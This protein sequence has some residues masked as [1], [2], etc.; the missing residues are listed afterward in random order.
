MQSILIF[1][2][3]YI[4]VL[5]GS[6]NKFLEIP[7]LFIQTQLAMYIVYISLTNKGRLY[8]VCITLHCMYSQPSLVRLMYTIYIAVSE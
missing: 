6:S 8:Y 5:G 1:D 3:Y 7:Q 4:A 2:L